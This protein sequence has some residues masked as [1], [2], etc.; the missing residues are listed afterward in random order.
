MKPGTVIFLLI[1]LGGGSYLL[2]RALQGGGPLF[3]F[4]SAVAFG[5]AIA[6]LQQLFGKGP[7]GR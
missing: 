2:W 7:R 1:A 6:S 4:L 5:M 3:Y